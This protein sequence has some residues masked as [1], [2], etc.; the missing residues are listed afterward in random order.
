MTLP[1]TPA[2]PPVHIFPPSHLTMAQKL[3]ETPWPDADREIRVMRAQSQAEYL[4]GLWGRINHDREQGQLEIAAWVDG[5]SVGD[6]VDRAKRLSAEL[7]WDEQ[8]L[9]LNDATLRRLA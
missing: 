4:A 9:V 8:L 7:F 6:I 5:K 1:F 2:A 3:A